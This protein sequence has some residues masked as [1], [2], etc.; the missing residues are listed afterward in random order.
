MARW[1]VVRTDF[2]E[3]GLEIESEVFERAGLDVDLVDADP[4]PASLAGETADAHALLVQFAQV[5]ADLI[6]S[7]MDCRVI[8]RY[9]I[10]VD[11]V[12]LAAAGAAGIPVA[13]VPDYCIDEVSTQTIGFLIDLNRR[14]IALDRHVRAGRWGVEPPPVTAP[15]RLAG[16][17]LGIIGLGAIGTQVARKAAALG[18]RVIAHDP[19]ATPHPSSG[20][21]LVELA[22]VLADSDYLTLH[23]P[24]TE[25]TRGMI[26]ADALAAMRPTAYLLNLSRGPVVDQPAL[27]RALADRRI[28][29]AALDVLTAEPPD[30]DDPLLTLDNVLLTPHSSSWSVESAQQLRRGVAENVV[31]ALTG[32][33]PRSVVNRGLLERA[34]A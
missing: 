18:L 22:A 23:C 33:E 14:T 17:T 29:G 26:G 31:L 32:R 12:D 16:Q 20:V 30:P 13:N 19:Y 5:D 21:E 2:T 9:G 28:A 10:G 34:T 15:R 4:S 1:R 6:R 8:S 11:M 3:P 27:V 24:L 7:L 25:G